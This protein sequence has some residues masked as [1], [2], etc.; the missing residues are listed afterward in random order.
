MLLIKKKLTTLINKQIYLL[1]KMEPI[2]EEQEDKEQE[3]QDQNQED[4]EHERLPTWFD[5]ANIVWPGYTVRF[6][7]LKPSITQDNLL[8]NKIYKNFI[9]SRDCLVTLL[10]SNYYRPDLST[11]YFKENKQV[12]FTVKVQNIWITTIINKNDTLQVIQNRFEDNV[13]DKYKI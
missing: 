12:E 2:P 13:R 11:L 4:K 6:Y 7:Q 8:L 1:D 10:K 9:Q 5:Q 3:E